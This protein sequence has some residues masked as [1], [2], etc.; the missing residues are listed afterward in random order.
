MTPKARGALLEINSTVLA[1]VLTF[2]PGIICYGLVASL[3]SKRNRD[4]TTIFLQIFMY[5]VSAYMI[6]AMFNLMSPPMTARLGIRIADIPLL[7]PQKIESSG[8]D[9]VTIAAA[10]LVGA[11]QGFFITVGINTSLFMGACR[12]LR[13]TNRISDPNVWS[14]L[15]NSR[16][17]DNWVTIRNQERKHIY[18]GY[19][20]SFSSGDKG[21]ELVLMLVEVFDIDSAEKV[22]DIPILYLSFERDNIVLEFG[23]RPTQDAGVA[24]VKDRFAVLDRLC[25]RNS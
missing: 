25:F 1:L 19:V 12:L 23:A 13:I 2:I 9:P 8:I 11:M 15:M 14:F 10:S 20:R 7:S 17:T 21:R 5:G 4:N 22:G 6:L 24:G 18:Q 3:A 16:D